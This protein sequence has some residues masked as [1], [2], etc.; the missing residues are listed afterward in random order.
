M[1]IDGPTFV[2]KKWLIFINLGQGLSQRVG[3]FLIF[4]PN[5]QAGFFTKCWLF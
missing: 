5:L 3:C 1:E 4:K 2:P